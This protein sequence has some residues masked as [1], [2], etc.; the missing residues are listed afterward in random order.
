MVG[1]SKI[2]TLSLNVAAGCVEFPEIQPPA[3]FALGRD[4]VNIYPRKLRFVKIPTLY[5][6]RTLC[7]KKDS[8]TSS[9]YQIGGV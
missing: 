8:I 4:A 2:A 5:Y 1:A 7:E 6:K 3:N 9:S